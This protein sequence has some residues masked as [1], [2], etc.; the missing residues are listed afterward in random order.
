MAFDNSTDEIKNQINI[1]DVIGREV[2]LKKA[3]SSYKGL[4][5]FHNEK[6]PSFSVN[7]QGQYFNCFGC[8]KK[9]DVYRFVM[10]YYKIPFVD[11][12]EKLCDEYGIKKPEWGNRGPRIDYDKYY[13]INAKA[14]R[15]FYNCLGKVPNKGISYLVSRG[16]S[17]ETITAF[18]L[19]YAPPDGSVLTD[20]LRSEGV[21]DDDLLMLG[22]S[23]QGRNGLYDKFRDRVMFPIINSN[24]KVIGFGGR[25]IGDIK[26]KYLNSQESDVF[27]KKNNLFGLNL[28]RKEIADEGRA[29]IVEGYMD[30]ISLYQAGIKNV[31]ASLG[32]A[33][34]DNQARLL[35][36][37]TKNIVLSYDSDAAGINAALRGISVINGAGGKAKVMNVTDGKD[38][39]DFVKLHGKDAF[40]KLADKAMPA[41]DFRLKLAAEGFDL[42]DDRQILDYID[43]IVP[44]LRSLG[45]VEQDMYIKKLAE[46]FNIS[47]H[48]IALAV[49]QDKEKTE[50]KIS[51]GRQNADIRRRD[52]RQEHSLTERLE[53]SFLLL[54]TTDYRYLKRFDE[55]G[56]VFRTGLADK[57][58]SAEESLAG[59]L[60]P[61]TLGIDSEAISQALDPDDEARFRRYLSSIQIG[62][63]D[64]AFYREMKAGYKINN[65]RLMRS[66]VQNE[67][68]L[69]EQLGRTEDVEALAS[70]LIELDRLIKEQTEE[71]NA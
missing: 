22:L 68:Q 24:D 4:C 63:D 57:I 16:L 60:K 17:K 37:Y 1:V 53:I 44:V 52:M 9:G 30:L 62:P 26:P 55:D 65:Y 28:T 15:F 36:R 54:A 50:S 49:Q 25:A 12:V 5:P 3:G 34:T 18:G 70:K 14:A 45:P 35:C 58:R 8:G 61:G 67:L 43:R 56:I 42:S 7:E 11:A 46:Q 31:A 40:L 38:P 33:L 32:T 21:S 48:A 51:T 59:S 6:T 66:E 2:N 47:D 20:Y 23:S 71:N 27:L 10:D 41:T 19:G 64:E 29:I 13:A 69:A 39:D